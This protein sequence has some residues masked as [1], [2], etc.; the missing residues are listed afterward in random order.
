ML[1]PILIHADGIEINGIYYNLITKA[2]QAEVTSNPSK[3]SGDIKIPES[4]EYDGSK[5]DVTS[6]KGGAFEDCAELIS[7]SI[8]SSITSIG[9]YAF[10]RSSN[11]TSVYIADLSMWCKTKFGNNES[12]PFAF[13]QH[14]YINGEEVKDLVIPTG[15]TSIPDYAFY[16]CGCLLSVDISDGV[17]S[18]GKESFMWCSGLTSVKM[19]NSVTSLDVG[20]FMNCQ[21]LTSL[22]LSNSLSYISSYDFCGC[23]SLT[24][25]TIPNSVT[26][27]SLY[28]FSGCGFTSII[29][30]D[31]VTSIGRNAFS[32]CGSLTS[33]DIPNSVTEIRDEAFS[34]CNKLTTV[35]LG[36]SVRTIQQSAF[37]YCP[38]ITDVYSYA[39][40]TPATSGNA[41]EG[42]YIEAISLHVPEEAIDNYKAV[43]PWKNF[44]EIVAISPS[45]MSKLEASETSVKCEDG[46]LTVEGIDNGLTVELYSLN[47]EKRGSAVGK[48]GVAQIN[49]NLKAGNI[50]VIKIGNKSVKITIK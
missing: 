48:N 36:S 30:P 49:T 3:Y 5:Y 25:V 47:G 24:S 37:S 46:Q 7:I 18:I 42:S 9:E 21:N 26:L 19:A 15:V 44:K 17:T 39:T 32:Y 34:G 12:S 2:K 16:D 27:I 4:I 6:I 29:I 22:E 13:A 20:A 50:A 8:P 38:E 11:L 45:G 10:S 35:S 1:L 14:I 40:T 41:F 33:I 28:A 23:N 43:T 31:S